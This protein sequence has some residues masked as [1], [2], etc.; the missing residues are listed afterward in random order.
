MRSR[1]TS[2]SVLLAICILAVLAASRVSPPHPPVRPEAGDLDAGAQH[3][4]PVHFSTLGH[5]FVGSDDTALGVWEPASNQGIQIDANNDIWHSAHINAILPLNTGGYLIGTESGGAFLAGATFA[6]ALSNAW[7]DPD[8]SSM[9]F[10]ARKYGQRQVFVAGSGLY[11]NDPSDT[12]PYFTWNRVDT[13]GM[14]GYGY[15]RSIVYDQKRDVLVAA[16]TSRGIMWAAMTPDPVHPI[17]HSAEGSFVGDC[18]SLTL[19]PGGRVVAGAFRTDYT[20]PR[21]PI[22]YGEWSP[23]H[24]ILTL[25][26]QPSTFSSNVNPQNTM[27]CTSVASEGDNPENMVAVSSDK[28]G[29]RPTKGFIS[30]VLKSVDGG[31]SWF[32]GGYTVLNSPTNNGDLH[33]QS[34]DQG[35]GYNNCICMSSLGPSYVAI[36]WSNVPFVSV[37]GGYTWSPVDGSWQANQQNVFNVGLSDWNMHPDVHTIQ[38]AANDPDTII[39]GDDGGFAISSDGGLTA[40]TGQNRVLNTVQYYGNEFGVSERFDGLCCGGTQ[41]NGDC[42]TVA[43]AGVPY[44]NIE[45]GFDGNECRFIKPGQM[46]HGSG[47]GVTISTWDGVVLHDGSPIPITMPKPGTDRQ[48][49]LKDSFFE[50][51]PEVDFQVA[52]LN[53][54][55]VA[56]AGSDVYELLGDAEGHA[57]Q[58]RYTGTA[59]FNSGESV[60]AI[61]IM[62]LSIEGIYIGTNKG[63]IFV[64]DPISGGTT[65]ATINGLTDPFPGAGVGRVSGIGFTRTNDQGYAIGNAGERSTVLKTSGTLQTFV[66]AANPASHEQL[67]GLAIGGDQIGLF[68]PSVYVSTDSDVFESLDGAGSWGLKTTNLPTRAHLNGLQFVVHADRQAFLY[69]STYGRG[70]W[71]MQV[72]GVLSGSP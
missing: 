31:K 25:T 47:N 59:P 30:Q 67:T 50:P 12:L 21:V 23:S 18:W 41:D 15:I 1:T 52:G 6:F 63:K 42:Y 54:Y 5:T 55:A 37:N 36:G 10:G 38:F 71:R 28:N 57:L 44:Q 51:V 27:L 69:A 34:G 2:V 14:F 46:I 45:L 61:G 58:W 68:S 20:S 70:A 3:R 11:V 62:N 19:G 60:T 16:T 64:M 29:S 7:N 56:V 49:A 24:Q 33:Q 43:G 40:Q 26:M 65:L 8:I 53:A 66:S 35:L 17:W 22:Y 72:G 32:E 13:S 4:L 9:T 39:V 48:P